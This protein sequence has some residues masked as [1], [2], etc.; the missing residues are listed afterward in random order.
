MGPREYGRIGHLM[1]ELTSADISFK[2]RVDQGSIKLLASTNWT[3]I[4]T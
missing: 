3:V 1:N 2:P 4:D